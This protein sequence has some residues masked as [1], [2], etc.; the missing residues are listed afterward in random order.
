MYVMIGTATPIGSVQCLEQVFRLDSLFVT[1]ASIVWF[2]PANI[3]QSNA[4]N[5]RYDWTTAVQ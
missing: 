2:W 3:T 5:V 4:W 1:T